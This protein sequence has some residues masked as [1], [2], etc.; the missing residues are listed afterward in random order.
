MSSSNEGNRSERSLANA[1]RG[2]TLQDFTI[3]ITVFL[4]VVVFVLGL[5]PTFLEP[6]TAGTSGGERAQADMISRDMLANLSVEN[7]TGDNTLN[8]TELRT[9]LAGDQSELQARYGVPEHRQINIT[10][11][12][13]DGANVVNDN[14][15]GL[16]TAKSHREETAGTASRIIRLNNDT[17]QPGCRL[18]VKVW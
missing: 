3:G 2:Q 12:T 17:C 10:V 15:V 13:L 4:L 16:A 6:F 9:V 11:R 1:T 7:S 14:G 18:V 5:F 8:A